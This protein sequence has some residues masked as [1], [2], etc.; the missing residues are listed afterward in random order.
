[1][2]RGDD[3]EGLYGGTALYLLA[4]G[5]LLALTYSGSWDDTRSFW[6]AT[7]HDLTVSAAARA[8]PVGEC[9]AALEHALDRVTK[10]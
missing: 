3:A 2:P 7:R 9:V 4:S 5:R 6:W 1:M 10:P 8:F